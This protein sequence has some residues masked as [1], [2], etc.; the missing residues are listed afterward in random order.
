MA[1][2]VAEVGPDDSQC[3]VVLN[4]ATVTAWKTSFANNHFFV[5]KRSM[6]AA[7]KPI[8]GGIP[9]AFPQFAGDGPLPNHGF[10]RTSMWTLK[11]KAAGR[12][13]LKLTHDDV[14]LALWPFKFDAEFQIEF[15]AHRMHTSL[16]IINTDDKQIAFQALQHTYHQV[17]DIDKVQIVGLQD[18]HY[19]DKLQAK[20]RC[21]QHDHALVIAQETDSIYPQVAA[22]LAT[23]ELTL[24]QPSYTTTIT[25]GATKRT[26]SGQHV[27]Q[28]CD[29][30]VWNPWIK[31]AAAM[32]DFGN[33][34]Y[35]RMVCVEPGCI[36]DKVQLLPGEVFQL[37]QTLQVT[38][39][40]KI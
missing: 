24:R 5:S 10:M 29:V 32:A 18:R 39:T 19:L 15:D 3:S 8:R 31:K 14:T 21:L 27:E 1:D 37:N 4:G 28:A 6:M 2:I 33:E 35:K 7:G 9:L 30:V 16:Q 36:A 12:I 25:V 23:A 22:G 13:R 26:A 20:A 17:S 34:E 40:S 11:S 38:A